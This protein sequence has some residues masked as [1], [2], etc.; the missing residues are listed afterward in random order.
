MQLD[1]FAKI[2]IFSVPF[3]G[4]PST[5]KTCFQDNKNG[6]SVG[7]NPPPEMARQTEKRPTGGDQK[8]QRI[9]IS[10]KG[11]P[12]RQASAAYALCFKVFCLRYFEFENHKGGRSCWSNF[13]WHVSRVIRLA[14]SVT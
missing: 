1:G 4:S 8:G 5:Q 11:T 9:K 10:K 7:N 2:G 3:G 14:L 13:M 12:P 6:D